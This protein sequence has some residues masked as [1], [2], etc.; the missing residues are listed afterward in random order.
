MAGRNWQTAFAFDGLDIPRV[1][2]PRIGGSVVLTTIGA[3]G[4]K[5]EVLHTWPDEI[6]Q[7]I[8]L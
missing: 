4:I 3:A 8:T 7:T 6:G 1:G 2:K 5:T